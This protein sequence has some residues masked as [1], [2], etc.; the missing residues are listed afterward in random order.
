[1]NKTWKYSLQELQYTIGTEVKMF[2][3][4]DTINPSWK[5][6]TRIENDKIWRYNPIDNKEYFLTPFSVA[7]A[8]AVD[9]LR[10]LPLWRLVNDLD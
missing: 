4:K 3:P 2:G 7:K 1:M 6:V 10:K 5:K 9:E 8:P